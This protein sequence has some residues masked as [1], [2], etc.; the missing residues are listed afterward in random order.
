MF[1]GANGHEH[2]KVFPWLSGEAAGQI[3]ISVSRR[4]QSKKCSCMEFESEMSPFASSTQLHKEFNRCARYLRAHSWQKPLINPRRFIRNQCRV[5]AGAGQPLGVPAKKAAF[6]LTPFTIVNGESVSESIAAYGLYEAEL[7]EAFLRLI[8]PGQVVLDIGMHIGYYA[9][10]FAQLT[11]PTGQVHAFEPTSST[12]AIAAENVGQFPNLAVHTYAVWSGSQ[13]IEFNDFGPKYMAFN[14]FKQPRLDGHKLTPTKF[15]AETIALDSFRLRLKKPIALVK[16]D[17][18]SA[19]WNIIEGAHQLLRT[20]RPLVTLEV[21]DFGAGGQS[22]KL[23]QFIEGSNY[24]TWEFANGR[25]VLHHLRTTY[26]YGNLI[27]APTECDMSL[28]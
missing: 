27:F 6:H 28:I 16:V 10:L 20:D 2:G 17:A 13:L 19:E 23:I 3:G 1:D 8:K 26:E 9:T 21:G 15:Q 4:K 11:G 22:A 12:R 7:T 24:R 18:E 14:S 25:F 5:R